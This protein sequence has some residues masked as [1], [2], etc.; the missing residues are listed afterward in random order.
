MSAKEEVEQKIQ[1]IVKGYWKDKNKLMEAIEWIGK[2]DYSL[3]DAI[4]YSGEPYL[5]SDFHYIGSYF[6]LLITKRFEEMAG[7][8]IG[9]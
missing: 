5:T 1:S 7:D 2:N 6:C 4:G 8:E 3:A 9:N